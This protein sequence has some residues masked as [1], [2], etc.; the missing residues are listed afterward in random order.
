M[1]ATCDLSTAFFNFLMGHLVPALQS[2]RPKEGLTD[3]GRLPGLHS[4][5]KS[6]CTHHDARTHARDTGT[7][8]RG[9]AHG[10]RQL[11]VI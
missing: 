8:G 11:S 4:A 10:H 7:D 2:Q 1:A 3:R 6:P 9:S 5:L